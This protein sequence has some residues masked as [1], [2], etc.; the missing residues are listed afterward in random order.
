[1]ETF[2]MVDAMR[3]KSRF[4]E[5][6]YGRYK[7][8]LKVLMRGVCH[9]EERDVY[10]LESNLAKFMMFGSA[11]FLR[12]NQRILRKR[13][14]E[15]G[16]MYG[17]LVAGM[18][19]G[20]CGDGSGLGALLELRKH[21][22]GCRTFVKQIDALIESPPYDFD[23]S[24]LKE[25]HMWNDVPIGFNTEVEKS[26]FLEGKAPE[27][28]GYD[29]DIA[30]GVLLVEKRKR[31]LFSLVSAKPT[32][33]VCICKKVEKLLEALGGLRQVL[34][35]NLVESEYLQ[36]AVEDT[37][38]LLGYYS[39]VV[40]FAK[41]LRWDGDIDVFEVPG[42]FKAIEAG[43]LRVREDFSY[44]PRRW[45]R[46]VLLRHIEESLRPRDPSI[47]VP[48]VPVLFDVAGDYVS[49]P[50]EDKKMS[51]LFKKLRMSK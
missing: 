8:Q 14:S 31:Q 46:D 24:S 51:E 23:V 40:R 15:F 44:I 38:A 20:V 41:E 13:K 25:R 49:Y 21:V 33:V 37:R 1:M 36:Q 35:E 9:G 29:A 16:A 30:R 39:K 12:S 22:V 47:G 45:A 3:S 18:L 11:R 4:S 6:D 32:R 27:D 10:K 26:E 17:S 19:G 2:E 48:F 43:V 5:G 50:V 34:D 28:G 42:L 7:D